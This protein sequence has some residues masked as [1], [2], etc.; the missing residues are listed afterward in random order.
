MN[1]ILLSYILWYIGHIFTG[2]SIICTHDNYYLA[3]SFVFF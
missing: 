3:I 1:Y 2:F